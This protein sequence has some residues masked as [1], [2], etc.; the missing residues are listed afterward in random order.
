MR[1]PYRLCSGPLEL[2]CFR[3]DDIVRVRP[4]I[5]A[6]IDHLRPFMDWVDDFP[7][8]DTELLS[9]LL[10]FR[11]R[12]DLE[13]DYTFGAFDAGGA[14]IGGCGLHPRVGPG[15]I[16]I[17][18]WVARDHLRQGLASRMVRVLTQTAFRFL[19]VARV[20]IQVDVDNWASLSI[21]EKQG[22][23][24][25]G[26]R[27]RKFPTRGE[28]KDVVAFS[29]IREELASSPC[30]AIEFEAFDGLDRPLAVS[31]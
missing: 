17:G 16:E 1:I 20:E 6:N 30:G 19:P 27:R 4:V 2:R 9:I 18:Y 21:P 8:Q 3:P 22:F 14:Y 24:R 29:M 11:G 15:G 13:Q 7:P 26:V 25:E 28:L 5:E 31:S 12:F 23:V 10:G